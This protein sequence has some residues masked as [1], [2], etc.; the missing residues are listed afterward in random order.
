M[1]LTEPAPGKYTIYKA[2]SKCGYV[3][4]GMTSLGIVQRA[5]D[6]KRDALRM[7]EPNS[8]FHGKI[9]EIGFDRFHWETLATTDSIELGRGMERAATQSWHEAEPGLTLNLLNGRGLGRLHPRYNEKLYTFHHPKHGSVTCTCLELRKKYNIVDS[10]LRRIVQRRGL[11]AVGWR[12]VERK[13]EVWAN[14]RIDKQAHT[15]THQVHGTVT[16]T[17]HELRTKYGL[18]QG[19]TS[20]LVAGKRVRSVKGWRLVVQSAGE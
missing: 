3:Y 7:Q 19:S 8:L 11:N 14:P 20:R 16:C 2:T 13:D 10:N 17:T 9:R 1:E 15:F 18:D 5:A 4:I 12:L 6:H